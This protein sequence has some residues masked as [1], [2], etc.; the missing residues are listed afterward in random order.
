M[1]GQNQTVAYG[2]RIASMLFITPKG[3]KTM[4][5][6]S[7]QS[8]PP[9]PTRKGIGWVPVVLVTNSILIVILGFAVFSQRA[10]VASHIARLESMNQ[11]M[12]QAQAD[13]VR[14]TD[15]LVSDVDVIHKRVGVTAGEINQAR[16]AAQTLKHQQEEAAQI[17]ATKA[18]S[19]DGETFKKEATAQM[20]DLKE[21]ANAKLGT[22]SGE[23]TGIK[24]ELVAT[25]EEFGRQLVD[26]KN[27]LSEGIARNSNELSELRKK[28]E[29]DYFEFDIHKDP[30][31]PMQRVADLQLA[32]MKADPK[33]H[34]Y[35]VAIQVDDNRLEKKDRTTNEPV[36][37][38]VGRDQLRYEV[39]VNS[40]DKDRIRGYLSAPKDKALAAEV[41]TLR[42]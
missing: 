12:R 30:K 18:N 37:F 27:V 13:N 9:N 17:L 6:S 22:V 23:V 5:N 8:I 25:K 39:V 15:D 33:N 41:P 1:N 2:L 34:K 14:K 28:G 24:K 40:V 16:Q 42:Q 19:S 11:E 36:Q 21:D 3:A 20:T 7:D 31:H 26:V 29:R 35:S 4:F 38:L 10:D 32:L